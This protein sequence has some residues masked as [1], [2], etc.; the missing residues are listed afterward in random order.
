MRQISVREI[1]ATVSRLFQDACYYLPEDVITSL[2]LARE[3]E[4]SPLGHEVMDIILQ[5]VEIAAREHIPL[6]SDTGV[7]VVFLE[8][9][10]EST[11]FFWWR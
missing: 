3:K 5:D 11:L 10:Q 8:I 9:G 2:K 6:C 4:E 1:T 7:A